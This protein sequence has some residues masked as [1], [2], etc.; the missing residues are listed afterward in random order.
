MTDSDQFCTA[1]NL[2]QTYP[3][4]ERKVSK[5]DKVPELEQTLIV[6]TGSYQKQYA[7]IYFIRLL[8]LRPIVLEA[9]KQRWGSYP[10]KPAYIPKALDIQTN[11]VCYIIGTVYIDMEMK[12]NVL[13]DLSAESNLTVPPTPEKYRTETNVISLED[14]SGRVKLIG[15]RLDKEM[16]VTGMVV[17]I[18]GKED[19][20]SGAFE[21]YEVCYPG[22]P[23]QTPLPVPNVDDTKEDKYVAILSGLNIGTKADNDLNLQLL[24]EYISGELGSGNDQ[25]SNS[26]ITRVIIAG[27]SISPPVITENGKKRTYGYDATTYDATPMIQLDNIVNELCMTADVDIMP[28]R[29]DPVGI[30]LPQQPLQRFLFDQSKKLSSFHTVTNPYWCKLDD[31]LLLGTSGQNIDDIYKYIEGIDR[32]KMAEETLFWRH[33]APSAPDTLWCHPFQN[34]DPFLLNQCPHIYFIGNQPQFETRILEGS[35]KQ[36]V[37]VILV[38]SF[39]ESGTI[40]LVNLSTLECSSLQFEGTKLPIGTEQDRMDES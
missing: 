23:P 21:A 34:H 6:K 7:S 31:T 30:H 37:R 3:K 26:C 16:L 20:A 15:A 1:P 29:N 4:I 13:R 36:K 27:N 18:L 33:M 19:P 32:L 24:T 25:K 11:E 38:P 28:G 17:G 5:Y 14:E 9:A 35:D 2:Q 22:L 12:P 40:V 8:H 39:E 10:E